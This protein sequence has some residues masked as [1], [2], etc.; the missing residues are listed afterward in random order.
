MAPS[1]GHV[2]FLTLTTPDNCD[3][4][5][6]FQKR[7]RSFRTHFFEGCVEFGH[8]LAVYERRRRGAWHL[9]L[10]VIVRDDIRRGIDW[11]GF[12]RRDYRSASSIVL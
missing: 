7:W 9:H 2:G 5:G 12:E 10:L 11:A 4:A 1:L 3:D 8:W 6:D